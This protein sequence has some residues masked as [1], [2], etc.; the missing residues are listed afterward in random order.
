MELAFN[1]KGEPCQVVYSRYITIKGQR[2][3]HPTG[4][5]FRFLVPLAA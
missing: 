2:I 5:V 4:G 3:Y 1:K